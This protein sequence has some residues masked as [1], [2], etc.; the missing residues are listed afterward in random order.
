MCRRKEEE[1][2]KQRPERGR[3]EQRMRNPG[4]AVR[5]LECQAKVSGLPPLEE[6]VGTEN[7]VT[8]A[9]SDEGSFFPLGDSL[10]SNSKASQ[11][12][13]PSWSLDR[14]SV[15][16]F[17]LPTRRN[18]KALRRQCRGSSGVEDTDPADGP[19]LV[20]VRGCMG[21]HCSQVVQS[22]GLWVC[23][24]V[25]ETDMRKGLVLVL[26]FFKVQGKEFQLSLK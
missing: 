23:Q 24:L 17:P 11:S 1:Q 22:G 14:A 8:R 16:S 26:G 10:V 4:Q 5:S 18:P 19:S 15:V 3:E 20:M 9:L 25:C 12:L 13:W 21:E 2:C 7:D 6:D